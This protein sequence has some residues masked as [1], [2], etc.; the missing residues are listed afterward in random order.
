MYDT[1]LQEMTGIRLYQEEAIMIDLKQYREVKEGIIIAENPKDIIINN[2]EIHEIYFN[3]NDI[4]KR[5]QFYLKVKKKGNHKSMMLN[6]KLNLGQYGSESSAK[7]SRKQYLSILEGKIEWMKESKKTLLNEFYCKIKLFQ[8][9]IEKI[10]RY[11]R[12]EIYLKSKNI[13]VM[14]DTTI[15][16]VC[17]DSTILN[18][19]DSNKKILLTVKCN[20]QF[21]KDNDLIGNI[22][23]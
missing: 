18:C 1:L 14:L 8:Y 4:S 2:K 17:S 12:E 15:D 16:K 3:S 20:K 10:A 5:E 19:K 7:L 21:T 6:R 22:L 9:R 23:D 11:Y 13:L